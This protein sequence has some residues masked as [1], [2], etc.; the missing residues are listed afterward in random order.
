VG[1]SGWVEEH[2]HRGKVEG[3]DVRCGKGG[4]WKGNQEVGYH[5]RCKQMGKTGKGITFEM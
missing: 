3:G 5:L 2:T 1:K 4:L